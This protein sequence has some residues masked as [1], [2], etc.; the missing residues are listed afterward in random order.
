MS[1]IKRIKELQA[2]AAQVAQAAQVAKQTPKQDHR[3]DYS[4][5]IR[6]AESDLYDGQPGVK[7][8]LREIAQL[9][10]TKVYATLPKESPFK[11][12]YIGWCFASQITLAKRM[13]KCERQVRRDIK[14]LEQDTVIK[15]REWRDSYGTP[16]KEYHVIEEVVIAHLRKDGAARPKRKA[17]KSNTGTFSKTNQPKQHHMTDCPEGTVESAKDVSRCIDTEIAT[18]PPDI[19]DGACGHLPSKPPDTCRTVPPD[20]VSVKGVDFRVLTLDGTTDSTA[21]LR[22]DASASP[23]LGRVVNL[24]KEQNHSLR[25]S[26]ASPLGPKTN[27]EQPQPQELY[28]YLLDSDGYLLDSEN[29]DQRAGQPQKQK[30]KQNHNPDP[31]FLKVTRSKL[32]DKQRYEQ[33]T[34]DDDSQ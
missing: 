33:Y 27:Q 13:G 31:R 2:K 20:I 29:F 34:W 11:E 24:K 14:Q 17:G 10:V 15:T 26:S 12:D 8:T 1:D 9:Q 5:F 19:L 32:S 28:G 25:S 23:S 6:I 7:A 21:S 16:H 18:V 30:Q 22:S 3:L 4:E